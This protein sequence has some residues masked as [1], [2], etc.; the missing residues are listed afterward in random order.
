[1]KLPSSA[2]LKKGSHTV[3]QDGANTI[4]LENDALMSESLLLR[5]TSN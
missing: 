1:M 3:A 5:S 2:W 4:N